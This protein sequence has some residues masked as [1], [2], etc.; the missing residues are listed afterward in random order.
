[1]VEAR[2]TWLKKKE[3]F[4]RIIT[5]LGLFRQR[6]SVA[7]HTPGISILTAFGVTEFSH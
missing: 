4:H 1:M 7:T 5:D 3:N 2:V 6:I